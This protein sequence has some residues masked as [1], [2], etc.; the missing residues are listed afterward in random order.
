[1]S[2]RQKTDSDQDMEILTPDLGEPMWQRGLCGSF[3]V[4]FM[5]GNEINPKKPEIPFKKG[6]LAFIE[7]L[8][9]T[10]FKAPVSKVLATNETES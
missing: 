3:L 9:S 5:N 2:W 6:S 7:Y 1:M 4:K 8:R 10:D